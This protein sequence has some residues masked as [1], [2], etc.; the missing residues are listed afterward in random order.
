MATEIK[1]FQSIT[2]ED[3]IEWCKENNQVEWLKAEA[4]KEVEQKTY[5]KG[6]D[7][8][9]DKKQ[10]PIGTKIVPIPYTT[11]KTNFVAEFF[12]DLKGKG[13]KKDFRTKIKE[14]EL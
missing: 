12:P 3:I 4:S 6:E 5:P 7:G 13:K 1:D 11:L 2:I 9:V 8:K 10:A 14:L